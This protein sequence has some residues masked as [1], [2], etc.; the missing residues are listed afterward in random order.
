MVDSGGSGDENSG[1][2]GEGSF[3]KVVVGD[4]ASAGVRYGG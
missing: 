2:S 1:D 3:L 4:G